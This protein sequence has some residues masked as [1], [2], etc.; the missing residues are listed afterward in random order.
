MEKVTEVMSPWPPRILSE[1]QTNSALRWGETAVLCVVGMRVWMDLPGSRSPSLIT[2][3]TAQSP[4]LA[5]KIC[6]R[7]KD[8]FSL[9]VRGVVACLAPRTLCLTLSVVGSVYRVDA[10]CMYVGRTWLLCASG[11]GLPYC[12]WAQVWKG[13]TCAHD[14]YMPHCTSLVVK[15]SPPYSCNLLPSLWAQHLKCVSQIL[16]YHFPSAEWVKWTRNAG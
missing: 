1:N 5:N 11:L 8:C 4:S 12:L 6:H 2:H 10:P 7:S 13:S 16:V 15:A 9:F 3:G 14:Q